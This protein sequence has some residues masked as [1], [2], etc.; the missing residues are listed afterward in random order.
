MRT[1]R[2]PSRLVFAVLL[3]AFGASLA[4]F[5]GCTAVQRV[6]EE[7]RANDAFLELRVEPET[8]EIYVDD[9]YKGE[10]RGWAKGILPLP[11]G[12]HRLK[13]TADGYITE[14]FDV[15]VGAGETK[16]LTLEME[17]RLEEFAED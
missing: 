3:L 8:A 17:P 2:S 12:D 7:G 10:V 9:E 11:P 6:P 5:G 16:R 13:L 15:T 4:P 1:A 14:R